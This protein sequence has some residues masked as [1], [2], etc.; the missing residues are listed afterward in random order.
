MTRKLWI[1]AGSIGAVGLVGTLSITASQAQDISTP[2]LSISIPANNDSLVEADTQGESSEGGSALS[3][4]DGPAEAGRPGAVPIGDTSMTAVSAA[5]A[6]SSPSAHS[7]YSAQSA[8]SA[9]SA[10]STV[11][12]ASAFSA[13]S[14]GSAY[15]AESAES[16]D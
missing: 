9:Q 12:A 3:S 11:S 16:A 14:A 6:Y 5:S 15:S 1:A 2:G 4:A 7:A 8:F 13:Y 10:Y